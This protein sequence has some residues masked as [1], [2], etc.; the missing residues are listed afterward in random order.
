MPVARYWRINQPTPL[1]K[2]SSL[3]FSEIGFFNGGVRVDS[4]AALSSSDAPQSGSLADLKDNSTSQLVSF[5]PSAWNKKGFALTWDFGVATDIDSLRINAGSSQEAS[6][7]EFTL[8][9]SSDGVTWDNET[10]AS[11]IPHAG[12]GAPVSIPID[13]PDPFAAQTV[14]RLKGEGVE[15]SQSFTDRSQAANPLTVIGQVKNTYED[16]LVRGASIFV[17]GNNDGLRTGSTP[18]FDFGFGDYTIEFFHKTTAYT[19]F[20]AAFMA[21]GSPAFSFGERIFRYHNGDAVGVDRSVALVASGPNP[22][23]QVFTPFPVVAL[24]KW[25]HYALCRQGLITRIFVDGFEV[26]SYQFTRSDNFNNGGFTYFFYSDFD[27]Q[28]AHGYFD[29]FCVTKGVARYTVSD[30]LI[31]LRAAY[32]GRMYTGSRVRAEASDSTADIKLFTP[33]NVNTTLRETAQ[34]ESRIDMIFGGRGVISGTVKEQSLPVNTPL[35]RRVRLIEERSG[36]VVAETWSDAVTGNY[37]FANIDRSLTY[38]VVSY[39]HTGL[40]R[41]VIADRLTPELMS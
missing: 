6:V 4:S 41:A 13:N 8:Q 31:P 2:S 20:F 39:D 14:L 32:R 11:R 29:E 28:S 37:S 3:E 26:A 12:S 34:T 35:A 36:Y 18:N 25:T 21:S 33:Q 22:A 9:S 30:P 5:A 27:K 16:K 7:F 15:G 40:Y 19:N 24:G 10:L 17:D 23:Y 38:T 1:S